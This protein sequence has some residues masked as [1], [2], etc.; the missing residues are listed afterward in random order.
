MGLPNKQIGWSQESNLLWEVLRQVVDLGKNLPSGGGGI[1][2]ITAGTGIGVDNTDPSNLIISSAAGLQDVLNIS[3]FAESPNQNSYTQFHLTDIGP[4]IQMG[5]SDGLV[6][7]SAQ[8]SVLGIYLSHNSS[9]GSQK[10]YLSDTDELCPE[11]RFDKIVPG[12]YYRSSLK[13]P[14][15]S[16]NVIYQTPDDETADGLYTLA[17]REWV[18]ANAPGGDFV[19]YTGAT[20]NVD[21][22]EYGFRGGDFTGDPGTYNSTIR[23]SP[24]NG[25]VIIGSNRYDPNAGGF[26]YISPESRAG[27]FGDGTN[28][29]NGT[30]MV[31]EDGLRYITFTGKNSETYV[32]YNFSLSE[33]M[34]RLF[35]STDS[36][37]GG[38]ITLTK[39]AIVMDH[40]DGNI[41]G[42]FSAGSGNSFITMTGPAGV[43]RIGFFGSSSE[44]F[45]DVT[46]TNPDFQ[47]ITGGQDFS[48]NYQDNSYV[49]KTW[50]TKNY[51]ALINIV[52]EFG[53]PIE[54]ITGPTDIHITYTGDGSDA[55]ITLPHVELSTGST[56]YFVTMTAVGTIK[57]LTFD[58][59]NT[60]WESGSLMAD[61]NLGT[62]STL[63]LY[64]NGTYWISM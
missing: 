30:K 15:N 36:S 8:I 61:Y 59:S 49:Q 41:Q 52:S 13:I 51:L 48:A 2:S 26:M 17:T 27:I 28:L 43:S 47:G 20:D 6:S 31:I 19:P 63:K 53:F 7:S 60:I 56:A 33:P 29:F 55:E 38:K 16:F 18:E 3:D 5:V 40:N 57:I 62:N 4:I 58:G 50:V 34:L 21:L 1:S 24:L 64:N 25:D 44:N 39:T 54:N 23:I 12:D 37:T 35:A 10:L 11:I 14:L 32:E 45:V 22:G 42:R 46:S 9:A